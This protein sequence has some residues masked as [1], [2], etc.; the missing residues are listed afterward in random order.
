MSPQVHLSTHAYEKLMQELE[1]L[2]HIEIGIFAV[3]LCREGRLMA[4]SGPTSWNCER[5]LLGE[6]TFK[7]SLVTSGVRG[8][9]TVPV[10]KWMINQ[11]KRS[12]CNA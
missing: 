2:S 10:S 12:G 6:P 5:Q 9:L 7:F 8:E 3:G 11:T 1:I 4:E